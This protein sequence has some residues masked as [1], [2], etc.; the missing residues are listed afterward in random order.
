[1]FYGFHG[2]GHRRYRNPKGLTAIGRDDFH[3]GY[4]R[5]KIEWVPSLIF[6]HKTGVADG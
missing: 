4:F 3:H 1:V 6:Q 2:F 5:S